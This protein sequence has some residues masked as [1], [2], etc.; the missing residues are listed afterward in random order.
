[1]RRLVVDLDGTLT[2]DE[3]GVSYADKRPNPGVVERLR[4][5]KA[6]GFEIVI[7]TARNMRTF[8]NSI[9][10]INAH[11]LP[12]V[13]EWLQRNDVPYDEIHVGKPWCGNDGF[14]IDDRCIRPDE[15]ESLSYAQIR[16]LLG[17]PPARDGA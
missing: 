5:Y 16:D 7:A 2:I 4:E 9:G 12:V 1:L 17:M 13:I 6:Q 15:F 14:Y 11:T 10:R 8:A 3:P